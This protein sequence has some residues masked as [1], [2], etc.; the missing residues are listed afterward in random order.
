M[1]IQEDTMPYEFVGGTR[2]GTETGEFVP[3]EQIQLH[4]GCR[5]KVDGSPV[6]SEIY[7]L[8]EDGK[9]HY[10]ATLASKWRKD[11]DPCPNCG[12]KGTILR[13][14]VLPETVIPNWGGEIYRFSGKPFAVIECDNCPYLVTVELDA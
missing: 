1:P 3:D 13:E 7:L 9:L 8:E 10:R 2:N 11:G 5:A 12:N 14:K 6:T 4:K